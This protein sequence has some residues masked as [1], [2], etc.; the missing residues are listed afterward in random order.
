VTL[1]GHVMFIPNEASEQ[2]AELIIDALASA[3]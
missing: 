3:V 1:P 2:V